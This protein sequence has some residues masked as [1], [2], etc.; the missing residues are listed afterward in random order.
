MNTA[1]FYQLDCQTHFEL[2]SA[3]CSD[4]TKKQNV[5][6]CGEPTKRFETSTEACEQAFH[7]ETDFGWVGA[8]K[9]MPCAK[10]VK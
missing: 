5:N 9:I 8:Y 4:V 10:A 3:T 2:H 6:I 1:K 7:E